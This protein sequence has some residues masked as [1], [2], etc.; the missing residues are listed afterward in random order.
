MPFFS[1]IVPVYNRENIIENTL[2]SIFD[3]SYED[4]EVIVVDDGSSDGT[5]Q[6]L[7]EYSDS[8]I[9]LEQ[10]NAGPGA[11]RNYGLQSAKGRYV[12]FLDSDDLWFPWTLQKYFDVISESNFPSFLS[13]KQFVFEDSNELADIQC[14]DLETEGFENYFS[15]Y[16]EWRWFGVS[17]FV[18]ER[19]ALLRAG[20]FRRGRVNGEDAELA[21]KL[22]SEPGFVHIKKP[23]MFAYR[24]HDGNITG[25]F[26]K[27]YEAS[28]HL[29]YMEKSERFSGGSKLSKRR[30]FI[31]TRHV[32]PCIITALKM[33]FA[34]RAV[35]L[36]RKTFLWH[37]KQLKFKFLLAFFALMSLCLLKI[38]SG[39]KNAE[40]TTG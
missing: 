27:N 30:R 22:G 38:I 12:A 33:G 17:S 24:A 9:I 29:I 32:R 15:S 4:F 34:K 37:L 3:Q 14:S 7:R 1:V 23:L 31:I 19:T 16:D 5:V 8:I 25:N 6:V 28:L 20:G 21:M 35:E 10:E 39:K 18:I 40:Q 26:E 11:A 2:K 36:Y 13:G